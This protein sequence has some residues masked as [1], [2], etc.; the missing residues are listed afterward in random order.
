MKLLSLSAQ[1][2]SRLSCTQLLAHFES[3][4]DLQD[5]PQ[6]RAELD[7][8]LRSTG[9]ALAF[10]LFE[11]RQS[12]RFVREGMAKPEPTLHLFFRRSTDYQAE[13]GID[14]HLGNWDDTW[15]RTSSLR[16][17]ANGI[18]TKHGLGEDFRSKR[19][20]VFARS[21]EQRCWNKL[22]Y[23]SEAS[24]KRLVSRLVQERWHRFRP[25]R[26]PYPMVY[27]GS[28]WNGNAP[29]AFNVIFEHRAEMVRA[30][31]LHDQI[32]AGCR[33]L[34]RQQR[35]EGNVENFDV[36]IKLWCSEMDLPPL[37]RRD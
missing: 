1:E 13:I 24:V 3:L 22:A 20:F 18:F 11:S 4:C 2:E 29:G 34:L 15:T 32:R 23:E 21:W 33:E 16:T 19:S 28:D 7:E 37:Y 17:L 8:A 27:S 30:Q 9:L 14:P 6:A 5:Y 26:K 25:G 12:S 35:H 31:G 10:W 36:S